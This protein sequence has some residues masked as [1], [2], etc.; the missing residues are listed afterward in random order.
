MIKI[1][2]FMQ[3]IVQIALLLISLTINLQQASHLH[4]HL[5]EFFK[6]YISIAIDIS[7]S[8][9]SQLLLR[10]LIIQLTKIV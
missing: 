10:W 7:M 4:K 8:L 5:Q 2:F 3:S 1:R 6:N 9:D